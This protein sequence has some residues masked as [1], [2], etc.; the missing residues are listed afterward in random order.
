MYVPKSGV[1]WYW[2][3]PAEKIKQYGRI[4]KTMNETA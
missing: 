3:S 1:E 2:E 4:D